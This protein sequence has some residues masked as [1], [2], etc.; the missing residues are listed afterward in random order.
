MLMILV[1]PAKEIFYHLQMILHKSNKQIN[2]LFEWFCS[3]K[4]SL[5]AKKTKY[6]VLRPKHRRGDLT[7]FNIQ[8]NHTIL[9]IIANDC[10]EKFNIEANLTWKYHLN[11]VKNKVA[12]ALFSIKQVK[13]VLS[14]EYIRTLYFALTNS[15]FTYEII[16]WGYAAQTSRQTFSGRWRSGT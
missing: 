12:R 4:W 15:H 6:I 3:N 13:N 8:I 9:D 16:T 7:K 14:T 1:I 10:E 2:Q 5:N 11:E